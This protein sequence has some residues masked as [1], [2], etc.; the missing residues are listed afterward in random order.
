MGAGSWSA[1]RDEGEEDGQDYCVR[2]HAKA[3]AQQAAQKKA[4]AQKGGKSQLG[5]ARSA[6]LKITCPVCKAPSPT[7]KVLG[8]HFENKHPKAQIPPESTFQ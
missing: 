2:G 8:Q 5:E 6:G 3:Q 7:Y 1:A 4:D